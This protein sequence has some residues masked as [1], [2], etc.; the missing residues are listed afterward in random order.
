[1]DRAIQIGSDGAI[2]TSGGG[3]ATELG[4]VPGDNIHM[5]VNDILL[6]LPGI[7]LQNCRKVT[8]NVESIAHLSAMS[9][10]TLTPLIGPMNA[11]KLFA[12]FINS[13]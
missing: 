8:D 9:V 11:K 1:V 13:S 12:F 6:S 3:G 7:N 2:G 10:E 4:D 5:T